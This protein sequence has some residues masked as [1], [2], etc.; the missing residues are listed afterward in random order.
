MEAAD[1]IDWLRIQEENFLAV[2]YHYDL[3]LNNGLKVPSH[4]ER[5]LKYEKAMKGWLAKISNSGKER[6]F[7]AHHIEDLI[8]NIQCLSKTKRDYPDKYGLKRP[9]SI[10]PYRSSMI[11][12]ELLDH[13]DP[14]YDSS[15]T[16]VINHDFLDEGFGNNY[17]LLLTHLRENGTTQDSRLA[18]ESAL[19]HTT[20]LNIMKRLDDPDIAA[21]LDECTIKRYKRS[22][23]IYNISR[24]GDPAHA[25]ALLADATDNLIDRDL[26]EIQNPDKT[27]LNEVGFGM[28]ILSVLDSLIPAGFCESVKALHA[29]VTNGNSKASEYAERY[30][31]LLEQDEA[32]FEQGYSSITTGLE[33]YKN[34]N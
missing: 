13:D 7:S 2:L 26:Y 19:I 11:L 3:M 6:I 29:Y 30:I 18:H 21:I 31:S 22:S 5:F 16:S 15:M 28:A 34:L 12:G 9:Y 8:T 32:F 4:H 23:R 25:I 20:P 17:I 33:Q 10:H 1:F 14:I 24:Y 27:V